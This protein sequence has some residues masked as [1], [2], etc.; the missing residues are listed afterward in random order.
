MNL[1]QVSVAHKTATSTQS[2]IVLHRAVHFCGVKEL[3]PVDFFVSLHSCFRGSNENVLLIIVSGTGIFD[4]VPSDNRWRIMPR[5]KKKAFLR[6]LCVPF[7]HA[8]HSISD[9]HRH[10]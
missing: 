3:A 1:L 9:L 6:N 10:C 2:R 4:I 7:P 5:V 8:F